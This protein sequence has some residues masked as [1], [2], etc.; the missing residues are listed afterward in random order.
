[1]NDAEIENE[2]N[3]KPCRIDHHTP[4]VQ[5]PDDSCDCDPCE[6]CGVQLTHLGNL[7]QQNKRYVDE[8]TQ[9]K[10]RLH[11]HEGFEGGIT[12]KCGHPVQC[13]YA[14]AQVD[15]GPVC[16]FACDDAKKIKRLEEKIHELNLR[17]FTRRSTI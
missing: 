7:E 15:G 3:T 2:Q 12:A 11:Q 17:D 16:C 8:I 14:A 4:C 9:L 13:Q 10:D 1:M 6:D 5:Y